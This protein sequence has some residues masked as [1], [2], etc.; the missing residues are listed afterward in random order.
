MI[1]VTPRIAIREEELSFSF[2]R[3]SG[4]G[5]QNVNKV[6]TAV[7]LRFD[8]AHSPSIPDYI[9]PRLL[10]LAGKRVTESGEILIEARRFRMQ[11]QNR[12]D[13][14][15]RLVALIQAAAKPSKKRR[16]T[17]PT[18]TSREKRITKKRQRGEVKRMRGSVRPEE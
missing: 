1:Q 13:A 17:K 3:S 15:I 6:S 18:L 9:R 2:V 8:A 14:V 12:Q 16:A 7:Q 5:G 4:P 10:R 11:E